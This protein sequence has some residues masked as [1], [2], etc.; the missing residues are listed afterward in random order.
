MASN[1]EI[2]DRFKMKYGYFN[3]ETAEYIIT[4]PK[5]PVKWINYVGGLDFGGFVDNTGGSL[6][7]KGD[8]AINRIV[9][10]IPQLP[11]SEFKGETL[12]IRIK[13]KNGY[14]AFSPYFV[15]TLDSCQKYECR[16]GLG[17][18]R[19]VSEFHNIKCEVTIFVPLDSKRVIRDIRLTNIGD[20]SAM[21]DV[22]P[23]VEYTHFEAL[24]QFNNN[25]WVPQ[26]MQ[27]HCVKENNGLKTVFQ[28]AFMKK[29]RAM[30]YYSSNFPV[31][32][33]ETDRRLFLGD[34][35]YGTWQNPKSLD[36]DELS[37]YEAKRGDNICALMH[38]LGCMRTGETKRIITQLGQ[39]GTYEKEID[40]INRFR[41][42]QT[43]DDEFNKLNAFW[44]DYLS[45]F[46]V[47]SP[48]K[49]FDTMV[50][51]HNPRQCYITKNWSR[52]LSLYQL[53]LGARGI[54][55]R[56]S[57]QDVLG[58][59]AHMP[60]EARKLIEKL[61]M[62]QLRNGSAMHQFNPISMI[63]NRGDSAEIEDRPDYYGDDHLWIVYSVCEYIKETGDFEFLHKKIDFYDKDKYEKP[64]ETGSVLE[65]IERAVEFTHNNMG[66]HGL[67]LLGFADWN[68][69]TNLPAGAESVF[70]ANQY[71]LAL[72]ELCHLF[73]HLGDVKKEELYWEYYT[74][75]KEA[76][77]NIC[78]DGEWFVRYFTNEGKALGSKINS[79]GKIYTN[80]QSWSVMSGFADEY[81]A[82]TALE[83][84]YKHLNTKNGIKLSFP[85]YDKF[86]AEKGGISTYPPGAK[87]N[88]GIFL[89]SNP[90]VM[91]AETMVG[92]GMRAM[93]YYDQINPAKKNDKIDEY[94]LEPYVYAQNILGD[95]HPQFGLGR[96][97][98]LSGTASWTY[99]AAV[100]YIL[101][102]RPAYEGLIID[103]CLDPEWKGFKAVR[104]YRGTTYKIE[105][106]NNSN[107]SKGVKKIYVDGKEI[108]GNVIL[109]S[110][111][112]ECTVKVIMGA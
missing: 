51:I 11:D 86:D 49:S 92:N 103:P 78:W 20:D 94:E 99:Q 63:A 96:N 52:Y 37:C 29:D 17:Y 30:N 107:I 47:E 31:S 100:K 1:T 43:V 89:H 27:S 71:G 56:D 44:Q 39:C 33:F 88:G 13:E 18:T 67:P 110:E 41:C 74:E 12:Y 68:D 66:A 50:N 4:N 59:M 28:Y 15:P 21:I 23:V 97:S 2:K 26:T 14:K 112:A 84:V 101:G 75:I 105:V 45:V 32:S 5:T 72:K 40:E 54:G 10:Y 90:W 109:P 34:S 7:C 85:G 58:V 46:N 70:V 64:L 65:H 93:Q 98:W 60:G 22:I 42:E 104:K 25:D 24:K 81:K 82:K 73:R 83:S 111:N 62:V 80:A 36:N 61:L 3:D 35:G 48:D 16:V 77:N 95:E 91:I 76:F 108:A 19:I 69:P 38:H 55:F 79:E 9:K 106:I 6:I 53:G 87:E 57:A 8:P 102:I